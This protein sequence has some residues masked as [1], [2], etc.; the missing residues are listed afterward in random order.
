MRQRGNC[1]KSRGRGGWN[2][3]GAAESGCDALGIA[4]CRQ[5]SFTHSLDNYLL[6]TRSYLWDPTGAGKMRSYPV[7]L[8]R[9]GLKVKGFLSRLYGQ[10]Q[11]GSNI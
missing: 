2:G 6:S 8:M 9:N 10:G 3:F 1:I 4:S 11:L 7:V 5:C